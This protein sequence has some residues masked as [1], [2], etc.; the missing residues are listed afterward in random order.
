MWLIHFITFFVSAFITP[1]HPKAFHITGYAQGTSYRI[2]YYADDTLIYKKEIDSAFAS[3][4][5]SLSLYK[6][7]SL[8]NQFNASSAGVLM[9]EHLRAVVKKSITVFRAT[10]GAFDITVQPLVEAWGFGTTRKET[11]PDS[12]A[13]QALL[14]CVSSDGLRLRRHRLWKRKACVRIDA[15]GIAQGYSVDVLANFLDKKGIANYLVEIGGEVRIRGRKS[16]GGDPFVIGIETPGS[17]EPG[18]A[19]VQ[20]RV[21]LREGALTTSGNYRKYMQYGGKTY[22]HLIHPRTGYPVQNE[23][24]SVTVWAPD[25]ITADG[26][27]NA[28][29]VM[30]LKKALAF[31]QRQKK[32]EAHFIYRTANGKTADTATAGFYK[33]IVA[34]NVAL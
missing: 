18:T 8:I 7:Y 34:D 2:T 4:D 19:P 26:Y 15:N 13:V 22:A 24:I 21:R 10:D 11:V 5:S 16:P 17:D 3:L 33:M 31:L 12:A 20:K 30:G 14:P 23:L 25:A 9:D 1:S 32:I 29:M 28:L 6:P 27:D